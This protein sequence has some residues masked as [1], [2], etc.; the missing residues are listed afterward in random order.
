MDVIQYSLNYPICWRWVALPNRVL[1]IRIAVKCVHASF[2]PWL[3]LSLADVI[4]FFCSEVAGIL[5]IVV[6]Y[7]I[8]K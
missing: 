2:W 8:L 5:E 4:I 7:F 1:K 3:V 6:Y